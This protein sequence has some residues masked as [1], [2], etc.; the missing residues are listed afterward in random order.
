MSGLDPVLGQSQKPAP[1]NRNADNASATT[2]SEAEIIVE[3]APDG[4][5]AT[6]QVKPAVFGDYRILKEFPFICNLFEDVVLDECPPSVDP[7]QVLAALKKGGINQGLDMGAIA[8]FAANPTVEPQIVAQG[9][10]P[11]CGKDAYIEFKFEQEARVQLP[12]DET[13]KIDWRQLVQ[14]PSVKE[15]TELAL[16]HPAQPGK[17]GLS[18]TGQ[19]IPAP[20]PKDIKLRAGEGCELIED[21]RVV[22][23]RNGRPA[24]I[25]G[26]IEVLPVLVREHGVNLSTGNIRFDG[27]VVVRGNVDEN[28]AV[29]AGGDINIIG[30]AH[31]ATLKAWG[32]IEVHGNLI[33][34]L[35]RAGGFALLYQEQWANWRNL[36]K[37]LAKCVDI[38]AQMSCYPRLVEAITREGWTRIFR[39]LVDYKL[40]AIKGLTER[41]YAA[42]SGIDDASV[43]DALAVLNPLRELLCSDCRSEDVG[44]DDLIGINQM[45]QA[46]L[47]SLLE[48]KEKEKLEQKEE[49]SFKAYYIQGANIKATGDII[50]FGPGCYQANL[51]AGRMVKVQG[52]PG[53]IRGGTVYANKEIVANEAGSP[54]GIPTVLKTNAKGIIK[55]KKVYPNVTIQVGSFQHRFESGDS[56]VVARI[57]EQERLRIHA[58][59]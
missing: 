16:K 21:M 19:V 59:W 35:A 38:M 34:G 36:A 26:R 30:N 53:I 47:E 9:T 48:Q 10:P 22:A 51:K 44:I 17:P 11:V 42:Y 56:Y 6:V 8:A 14:I 18:V 58:V 29:E 31:H 4:L 15:G 54:A 2:M 43:Q 41:L 57:D 46:Y 39:K 7:S 50:A 13:E 23:R 33:G 45:I 37:D 25:N 32:Q 28:M 5:S 1:S 12:T 24:V 27:D 20:E 3:I 52:R 55:I 49:L 40:P